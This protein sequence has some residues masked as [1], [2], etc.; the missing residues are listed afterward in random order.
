VNHVRVLCAGAL[1]SALT[2][3]A[4]DLREGAAQPPQSWAVTPAIGFGCPPHG[5]LNGA[6]GGMEAA[7]APLK[8][9]IGY[10]T[11]PGTICPAHLTASTSNIFGAPAPPKGWS[12]LLYVGV[13]FH[14]HPTDA[15]WGA[16]GPQEYVKL[17]DTDG[18][19]RGSYYCLAYFASSASGSPPTWTEPW[20][21]K[22]ARANRAK[23]LRITGAAPY[24]TALF[25]GPAIEFVETV[26]ELLESP[27]HANC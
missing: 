19:T 5:H 14:S 27:K 9:S 21:S 4:A 26:F 7:A 17:V 25:D 8:I 10:A 18:L 12:A 24:Y 15:Q 20:H 3:C 1:A 11:N 2:A 6:G 13:D 16:T 22:T 23:G